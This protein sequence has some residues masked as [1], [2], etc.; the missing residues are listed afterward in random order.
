MQ[1]PKGRTNRSM[2]YLCCFVGYRTRALLTEILQVL[3]GNDKYL[4]MGQQ[5]RTHEGIDGAHGPLWE[6]NA[7]LGELKVCALGPV[8]GNWM[9]GVL[10]S[11]P[12]SELEATNPWLPSVHA[13]PGMMRK[14]CQCKSPSPTLKEPTFCT[15]SL[16]ATC[17]LED[18]RIPSPCGGTH[19]GPSGFG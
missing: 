9:G 10:I 11:G 5:V 13:H 16:S 15:I 4:V 12:C 3:L 6:K 1:K 7:R 14:E 19:W 8:Q 17:F 2:N 18:S